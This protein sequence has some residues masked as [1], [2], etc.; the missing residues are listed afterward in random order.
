MKSRD[1]KR[2]PSTWIE[3][4]GSN[5]KYC[6]LCWKKF[7]KSSIFSEL[8]PES[9]CNKMK[10]SENL[11]RFKNTIFLYLIE[12]FFLGK[13][14]I[15]SEGIIDHSLYN[16]LRPSPPYIYFSDMKKMT[17]R[18][19]LE[20]IDR[21]PYEELEIRHCVLAWGHDLIAYFQQ[22]SVVATGRAVA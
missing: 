5:R 11:C 2:T 1:G 16:N 20:V 4:E 6:G 18:D 19:M 17:P 7:I 10:G 8:W 14:W 9:N 21:C 12:I 22:N 15:P 13:A 3:R